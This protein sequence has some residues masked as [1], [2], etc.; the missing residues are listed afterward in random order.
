MAVPDDVLD[1]LAPLSY[2]Q[3]HPLVKSG[4]LLLCSGDDFFSRLI[5][6]ATHSRWSH[7]ALA[8]RIDAIDRVMVLEAVEKIGVRAVT[9]E[10]FMSRNSQGKTPYPGSILLARHAA[11]DRLV[12]GDELK[13]MAGFGIDRLGDKFAGWDMIWIAVR[14]AIGR[15][16]IRLPRARASDNVF[17]CS[18][19]VDVCYRSAG[20]KIAWDGRGFIAPAD[21]ARDPAVEPVAHV[22]TR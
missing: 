14:I 10:S 2:E 9:L 4:D 17:I 11:T 5:R 16:N 7:I 19:Y 22:R 21:F 13:R 20:V 15:L 6:W 18:E 12:D 8:F 3:V 1:R